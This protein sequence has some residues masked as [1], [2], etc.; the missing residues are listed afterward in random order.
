[1]DSSDSDQEAPT[2]R[3]LDDWSTWR[4]EAVHELAWRDLLDL[5]PGTAQALA[6]LAA[7]QTGTTATDL[8]R[9]ATVQSDGKCDSDLFLVCCECGADRAV[10]EIK[11]PQAK[12]NPSQN[13]IWQT[14]VYQDAYVAAPALACG[15]FPDFSPLFILLD[16]RNRSRQVIE[17]KESARLNIPLSLD[18]W[19]VLTYREVL[20][21]VPFKDQPLA[22]W[23]LAWCQPARGE[24]GT[25]PS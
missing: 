22:R 9:G 21:R 15:C 3:L 12:M 10:I 24:A 16:T 4:L 5:V 17:E 2:V 25:A 6:D 11:G 23:L 14:A 13:D 1:M 20:T 8:A 18:G 7:E 19:A